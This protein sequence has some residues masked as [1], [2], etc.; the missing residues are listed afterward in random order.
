MLEKYGLNWS[1]PPEIFPVP[2][3]EKLAAYRIGEPLPV[4]LQPCI[5]M[6]YCPLRTLSLPPVPQAALPSKMVNESVSDLAG[7]YTEVA[8]KVGTLFG[9][10]GTLAGGV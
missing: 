2:S 3:A 7:L 1:W 5:M 4:P 10:A 6:A 8:V 9:A